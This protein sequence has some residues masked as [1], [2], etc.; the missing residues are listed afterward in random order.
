MKEFKVN[1]YITLKM[2]GNQTVIYVNRI[3]FQICKHLIFN[4]PIN[5]LESLE[6]IDSIDDVVRLGPF[7]EKNINISP[8]MAFWGH[9]SV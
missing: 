9:C 3:K 7:W 6:N 1:D 8:E 4:I 2:E 5:T